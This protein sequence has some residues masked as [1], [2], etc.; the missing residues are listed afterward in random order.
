MAICGLHH[1]GSACS[2]ASFRDDFVAPGKWFRPDP[3]AIARLNSKRKLPGVIR[4]ARNGS[5][6]AK[7]P[8]ALDPVASSTAILDDVPAIGVGRAFLDLHAVSANEAA[9]KIDQWA[10]II[11]HGQVTR[12]STESS[13]GRIFWGEPTVR[14]P[15]TVRAGKA[16]DEDDI[17]CSGG[18]DGSTNTVIRPDH[19]T[20]AKPN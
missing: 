9:Q 17:P 4:L 11:I 3:L 10:F 20:G 15:G 12:A 5:T 14:I 13:R 1:Q 19:D 6:S 18:Y 2:P 7:Q 16:A 8:H